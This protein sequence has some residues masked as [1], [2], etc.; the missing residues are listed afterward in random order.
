M[1]IVTGQAPGRVDA[2]RPRSLFGK[3][4]RYT[5]VSISAAFGNALVYGSWLRFT[6]VHPTLANALSAFM[7]AFPTFLL[8]R[9][10][11]WQMSGK[12]STMR[13]LVPYYL[14]TVT[15]VTLS[16]MLAW[17]LARR[18]TSDPVLV[19]ATAGVYSSTW[20]LRFFFL[21]KVLFRR[22]RT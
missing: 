12:H 5:L 22:S 1:T 15:N 9:R 13:E 21:D 10:W 8:N 3:L 2:P 20:L 7:I 6:D 18:G 4:N 17:F 19:L 11:T 14:F 16:T